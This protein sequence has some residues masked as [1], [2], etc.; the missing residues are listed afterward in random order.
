MI[1]TKLVGHA[2]CPQCGTRSEVRENKREKL[3]LDCSVHSVFPYQ[4]AQ[5]QKELREMTTFLVS[6]NPSND[7]ALPKMEPT[8]P[9]P[10]EPKAQSSEPDRKP[11]Q[12]KRSRFSI[13][14]SKNP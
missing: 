2:S 4:S 9:E 10:L 6:E 14:G 7:G 3:L 8:E 11:V 5:A 12:K 1:K 13:F